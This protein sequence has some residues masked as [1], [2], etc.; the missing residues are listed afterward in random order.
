M[1]ALRTPLE[2]LAKKMVFSP[3]ERGFGVSVGETSGF[4]LLRDCL[5]ISRPGGIAQQ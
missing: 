2:G 1:L 3:F 4:D 5:K